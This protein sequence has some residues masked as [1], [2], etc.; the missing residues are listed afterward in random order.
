MSPTTM[1]AATVPRGSSLPWSSNTLPVASTVTMLR[2]QPYVLRDL[3]GTAISVTEGKAIVA[4]HL[5]VPEDV[6]RR[7]R[8]KK[9]SGEAPQRVLEARFRSV[10]RGDDKRGDLPHSPA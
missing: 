2:Q 6:R 1:A 9:K 4:E 3:D 7:K 10:P 5:T 8:T